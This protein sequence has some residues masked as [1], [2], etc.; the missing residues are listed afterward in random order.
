MLEK[1]IYKFNHSETVMF[2]IMWGQWEAPFNYFT[3]KPGMIVVALKK[4][5]NFC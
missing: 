2:G 5:T 1:E 4:S 3:F